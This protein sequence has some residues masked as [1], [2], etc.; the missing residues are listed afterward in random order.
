M[1]TEYS[2]IKPELCERY[3]DDVAGA[4]SCTEQDSRSS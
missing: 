1:M 4:A 2:R 3:L